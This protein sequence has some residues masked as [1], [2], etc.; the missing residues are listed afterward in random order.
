MKV[1]GLD[2]GTTTICAIVV[3]D[4]TGVVLKTVTE[5]NDS[6][7][8]TENEW[9]RIQDPER[10]LEI[11]NNILFL[12]ET[13]I[14]S[15]GCIGVTGQMHGIL[16]IDGNGEAVGNLYTWQDRRGDLFFDRNTTYAAHLSTV[17]G[18]RMASGY[19]CTT[20]FYNKVNGLVPDD[21]VTLCTIQDYVAMRISGRSTPLM[22]VSNAASLGIFSVEKNAFDTDAMKKAGLDPAFFPDV[23]NRF[24]SIGK[25][26][27][28]IPVAVAIGDNQASFIGSVRDPL[29]SIL[30]N[31]GT[32]GQI[33]LQTERYQEMNGMETRPLTDCD[34]LLAGSSLCGGRAYAMLERFFYEVL[35]MAGYSCDSVYSAMDLCLSETGI[36]EDSALIVSTKFAGTRE[37]PDT[38]GSIQNIG[39]NNFTPLHLIA[40]FLEGITEELHTMI[41]QSGEEGFA[42]KNLLIGSG[43]G[44]RKNKSLQE[45]FSKRFGMPLCIPAHQ[46]E[47]AFGA[48]LSALVANGNY[49]TLADA[50][51]LIQYLSV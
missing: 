1:I 25:T 31:I 4:E 29:N 13:E 6:F 21:A 47:A 43:N 20:H 3:D 8:K 27:K 16:Y 35:K 46:E 14:S 5:K 17:T 42:G 7:I 38:R 51:K 37:N 45:I 34:F 24:Q 49:D 22:H 12:L 44:L 19:G 41:S 50:Q 2:I 33:S 39:L 48:A 18:H 15:I 10:I 40:G 28:N 32:G 30:V 23:T 26:E 9:E 36:P 11:C